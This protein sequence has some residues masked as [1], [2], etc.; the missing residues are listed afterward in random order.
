MQ[1]K[2]A[3]H[4]KK[5]AGNLSKASKLMHERKLIQ[6]IKHYQFDANNFHKIN[7]TQTQS[8]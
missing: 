7:A 5:K 2:H 1:R 8:V 6:H 3:Q 4:A